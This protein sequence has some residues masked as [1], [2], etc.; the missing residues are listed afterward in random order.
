MSCPKRPLLSQAWVDK[1][2]A[3]WAIVN[4]RAEALKA[5]EEALEEARKR[6]KD[7]DKAARAAK[8][9]AREALRTLDDPP[10]L[11]SAF[12]GTLMVDDLRHEKDGNASPQSF[13]SGGPPHARRP[14]VAGALATCACKTCVSVRS[15]HAHQNTR[16]QVR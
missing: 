7:A 10:P 14:A 1:A 12:A 15:L 9:F 6:A 4:A 3:D 8:S 5:A 2:R 13:L 16:R 11:V